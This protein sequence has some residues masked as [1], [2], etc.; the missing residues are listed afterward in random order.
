MTTDSTL[1][2][3]HLLSIPPEIRQQILHHVLFSHNSALSTSPATNRLYTWI[4]LRR[5]LHGKPEVLTYREPAILSTCRLIRLEASPTYYSRVQFRFTEAQTCIQWL[6]HLNADSRSEIQDLAYCPNYLT[7]MDPRH[8]PERA[9]ILG[10][11]WRDLRKTFELLG[12]DMRRVL[13]VCGYGG[14]SVGWVFAQD[15]FDFEYADADGLSS[16]GGAG[17]RRR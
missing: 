10:R 1:P 3:P 8:P 4:D 12:L 6:S 9:A 14:G 15:Y 2:R 5:F 11:D 16:G 7:W 13:R 17:T